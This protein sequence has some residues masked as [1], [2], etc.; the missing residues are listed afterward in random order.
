MGTWYTLTLFYS[1]KNIAIYIDGQFFYSEEL[2]AEID[3]LKKS[4]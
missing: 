1:G 4:K 2:P 3:R